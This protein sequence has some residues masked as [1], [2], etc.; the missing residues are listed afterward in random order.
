MLFFKKLPGRQKEKKEKKQ[1]KKNK[2]IP[3][4]GQG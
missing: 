4:L 2:N 1:K 3:G